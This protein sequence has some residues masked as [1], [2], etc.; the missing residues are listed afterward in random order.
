MKWLGYKR[1]AFKTIRCDVADI[2]RR[3]KQPHVGDL[4]NN[5]REHGEEPIHAPA[6]RM[7][8]RKLL[9]GRDRLAALSTLKAARLWVHLVECSD[10]EAREIEL[11]ENLYRRADNRTALIAQLSKLTEQRLRAVTAAE[12][13]T[14]SQAPQHSPKAEARRQVARAAGM[15]PAGVR[16]AEQRAAAAEESAAGESG[17]VPLSSEPAGAAAEPAFTY[18]L[19]VYGCKDAS[20]EAVCNFARPVQEAI[21]EA[22]KHLRR[23]LAALK[24]IELSKLGQELRAQVHRVGDL[25]RSERPHAICPWCKGLPKAMIGI[26]AGCSGIGYVSAEKRLRAPREC[27]FIDPPI[28]MI[29][30]REYPYA[31]AIAG[32][33]PKNGVPAKAAKRV[34]VVDDRGDPF[35]VDE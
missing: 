12:G 33:L 32:K 31:D 17:D 22:D 1:V 23:A 7:P 8:G 18:N 30:G 29:D 3:S 13:G 19:E 2:K 15:S 21:D 20:T 14:L 16:K 6:V 25:M 11:S 4:A 10:A 27:F 34:S 5:I 9:A 28:V 26:C 35:K 24:P